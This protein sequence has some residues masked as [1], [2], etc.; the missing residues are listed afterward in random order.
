MASRPRRMVLPRHFNSRHL[1]PLPDH[2]GPGVQGN[3][4][5]SWCV[6]ES[7]LHIDLTQHVKLSSTGA[8]TSV[9]LLSL[10]LF[11]LFLTGFHFP[12]SRSWN[13]GQGR[14]QKG[15]TVMVIA[16][17]PLLILFDEISSFLGI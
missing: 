1:E 6:H 10:A 15:L 2:P 13:N 7:L 5:C 3:R 8:S 12:Q 9:P 14:A 16:S 11:L 17:I 4:H